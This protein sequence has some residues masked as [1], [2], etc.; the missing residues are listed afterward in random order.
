MAYYQLAILWGAVP[1]IEDNSKLISQ[2]LL[3]RN[4][5]EDVYKFIA[6]DLT[7]A[8]QNLPTSNDAGRVT[9]WS[10][11]GLLS[12][13]YLTMAG[14]GQSGDGTRNQAYLD[15]A[16]LYAGNVCN[17]SGLALLD[18]YADLFKSQHNNNS[19]S[20]FALQWAPGVGWLL[21]NMLQHYSP[22]NDIMPQQTGAWTPFAPTYGLY[23]QYSSEDTVRR[24]ATFMLP[25]DYYEELNAA[26]WRLQGY[27]Q[28][29]EKTH[30]RNR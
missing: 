15:S 22:S 28:R 1:I 11:Q 26:G 9:T 18:N 20:L 10:A 8:A 7:F 2:P 19:E 13:V 3:Y 21:G 29:D 4:K 6:L 27:W 24:K 16:K 17:K 23:L 30:C 14:L 5:V 12:K 25:G